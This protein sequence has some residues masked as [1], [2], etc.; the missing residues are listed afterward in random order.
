MVKDPTAELDDLN[1]IQDFDNILVHC[2]PFSALDMEPLLK[3]RTWPLT[4]LMMPYCP[5]TMMKCMADPL[6]NTNF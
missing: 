3:K 2:N 4:T 5:W 6:I 1:P